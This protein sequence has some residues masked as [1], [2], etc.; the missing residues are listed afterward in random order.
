MSTKIDSTSLLSLTS[1]RDKTKTKSEKQSS[2]LSNNVKSFSELESHYC[3]TPDLNLSE[4][5]DKIILA[6]FTYIRKLI[7]CLRK[8]FF[9]H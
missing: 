4:E 8:T 5:T 3:E 2:I 9:Q 7:I 1:T 6:L